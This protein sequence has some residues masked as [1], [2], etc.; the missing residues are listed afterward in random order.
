ML[1]CDEI[2]AQ[3][4]DVYGLI[5]QLSKPGVQSVRDSDGS[6]IRYSQGS[7]NA[8]NARRMRLEALYQA[9]CGTTSTRPFGFIF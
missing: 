5:D 6:E 7:I 4:A 8:L 2:K 9:Q 3:L 1:T